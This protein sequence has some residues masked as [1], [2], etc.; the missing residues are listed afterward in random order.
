MSYLRLFRWQNLLVIAITQYLFRYAIITPLIHAAGYSLTFTHFD[1][2]L[3]VLATLLISAAGYAINDYFDLNA[4]RINK[5][6][7]IILVKSVSRRWAIFSHS[8]FNILAVL[9]GLYLAVKINQWQLVFIFLIVP[10]LL[11]LYS[12]RYKRKFLIGNIIIGV[13]SAFVIAVVWVF[14]FHAMSLEAL[15]DNETLLYIGRFVRIYAFFAF[16]TTLAREII[17][18]IEDIKGDVK[19]G[20]RTIPIVSGIR[21]TKQLIVFVVLILLAFVAYF[22]IYILR[23]DYDLLFTYILFAIQIPF[24]FIINKTLTAKEKSD[25]SNLS[26]LMKLVMLSG[27]FTMFLFYFYFQQGFLPE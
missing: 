6:T 11:W 18:D 21:A 2:S 15:P 10:T 26:I 4:D 13:L 22:Q 9:I 12:I 16:L 14:E 27:I 20:C 19:I 8:L 17:K 23:F 7:K 24:I 5:P 1:F 3:L 25:Y